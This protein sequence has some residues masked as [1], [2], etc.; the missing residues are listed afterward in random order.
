MH[1]MSGLSSVA[2]L[3]QKHCGS[4]GGS[5]EGDV[6]EGMTSGAAGVEAERQNAGC[7]SNEHD[8]IYTCG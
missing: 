6:T 7:A 4:A 8:M 2:S 1:W 3:P 5:G